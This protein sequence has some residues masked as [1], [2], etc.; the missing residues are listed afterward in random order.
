MQ[1]PVSMMDINLCENT[2]AVYIAYFLTWKQTLQIGV[3]LLIVL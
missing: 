2:F 1:K 3:Y